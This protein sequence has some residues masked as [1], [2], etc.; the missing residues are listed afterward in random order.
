M[1]AYCLKCKAKREIS[2]PTQVTF[3]NGRRATRG[4][5]QVCG[6]RVRIGKGSPSLQKSRSQKGGLLARLGL[7]R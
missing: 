4:T 2:S 6:T 3:T 7:R 1:D 5:C